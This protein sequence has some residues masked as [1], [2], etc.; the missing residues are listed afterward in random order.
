[1]QLDLMNN[2][3]SGSKFYQNSPSYFP[4]SLSH[5]DNWPSSLDRKLL[6]ASEIF[7]SMV[8]VIS[9]KFP[10]IFPNPVERFYFS[11]L[12]HAYP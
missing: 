11:N 2:Q 7:H 5:I 8:S 1:M 10:F 9:D 4:A 3:N 12:D 6:L